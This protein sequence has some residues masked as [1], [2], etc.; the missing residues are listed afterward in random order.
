MRLAID[1]Q[2]CIGSGLCVTESP[3]AFEL[4][5]TEV[6]PRAVLAASA[7]EPRLMDAARRCPTLAIR[8]W[9]AEGQPLYPPPVS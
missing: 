1:W 3:E 4:V 8:I 7:A 2:L 9:D 5:E 6:G